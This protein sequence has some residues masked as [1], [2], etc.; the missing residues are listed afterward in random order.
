MASQMKISLSSSNGS[1]ATLNSIGEKQEDTLTSDSE[2]EL[3][4]YLLS[5]L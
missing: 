2:N 3:G 1:K 5:I 4:Y